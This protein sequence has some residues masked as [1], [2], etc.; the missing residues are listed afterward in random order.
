M[1]MQN[2][3]F[4]CILCT[5][6]YKLKIWL[7]HLNNE[8]LTS[9]SFSSSRKRKDMKASTAHLKNILCSSLSTISPSFKVLNINKF[10]Q[11]SLIIHFK[12][13]QKAYSNNLLEVTEQLNRDKSLLKFIR[14]TPV[15][16]SFRNNHLK[17]FQRLGWEVRGCP[18]LYANCCHNN[19]ALFICECGHFSVH[20]IKI[21]MGVHFGKNISHKTRQMTTNLL[22]KLITVPSIIQTFP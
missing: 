9:P 5:V 11:M 13:H 20:R 3:Q 6:D 21:G 2:V 4:S 1:W 14:K 19:K 22:V 7:I 12:I 8:S 17:L 16:F 18:L 10:Q 15:I